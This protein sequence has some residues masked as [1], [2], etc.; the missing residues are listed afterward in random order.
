MRRRYV[1][2]YDI[3]NDKR[4]TKIYEMLLGYGDHIQ[5]SV[6]LADLTR[7]E[8]ITLRTRLRELMN[9]GE[10]Q[11]LFVDLGRESRPLQDTLE[12]IGKP[13]SPPVR[14]NIV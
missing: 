6:F 10:D 8:L 7:R 1:V 14:T 12:V 5:F 3:A 13:Y 9:E 4:R 2:S 11:C